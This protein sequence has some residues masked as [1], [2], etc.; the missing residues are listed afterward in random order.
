MQKLNKDFF[1][2]VFLVSYNSTG[3]AKSLSSRFS[4]IPQHPRVAHVLKIPLAF[5]CLFLKSDI[6]L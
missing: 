5:K 2:D 6:Y 3:K 1:K 4:I